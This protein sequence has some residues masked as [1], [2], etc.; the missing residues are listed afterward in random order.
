MK[1]TALSIRNFKEMIR[2]PL[3]IGFEMGIPAVFLVMF[4]ALG[5][6]VGEDIFSAVMLVPAVAIF[7][8]AFLTMFSAINL[9]R[10]RESAL[11]SRLL[12]TPLKSRDFILAY[13][14]PFVLIAIIQ[15]TVCFAVGALLGLEIHGNAALVLLIL[16]IKLLSEA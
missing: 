6:N 16:F 8:F 9:A 12:T 4:W 10:D 2:D 11:L 7:G 13:F 15:I 1:F 3:S 14:L 5:K